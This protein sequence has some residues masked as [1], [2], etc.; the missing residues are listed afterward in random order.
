M[1]DR[2]LRRTPFPGLSSFGDEDADAALFYGRSLEIAGALEELREMRAKGDE[3]P[4]V[5]LGASGSGKSSF[6]K[7]GVIPRLRREAPA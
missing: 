6:L 2:Q 5:I 1:I 3:R 4:Y 7:A